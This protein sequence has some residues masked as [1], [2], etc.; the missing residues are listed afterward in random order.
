MKYLKGV[1]VIY[2]FIFPIISFAQ[3]QITEIMYDLDGTDGG[4]EW[5]EIQ[6]IGTIDINP[7]EYKLLENQVNHKVSF[8]DEYTGDNIIKPNSYAVIA[9]NPDKFI[10]DYPNYAGLLLDSAFSLNNT[11]ENLSILDSENNILYSV[12][13]SPEWGAKGTGN[14]LQL[15]GADWIVGEPTPGED[16]A[17]KSIDE[18]E[19][20]ATEDTNSS[21]DDSKSNNKDSTSTH[22]GTN[23]LTNHENKVNFKI[24][25]GRHRYGFINTPINFNPSHNLDKSE[26]IKYKWS[27]GDAEYSTGDHPEHSYY[28]AGDYNV[29]LSATNNEEEVTSRTKVTIR[30][31]N[32]KASL[33]TSGKH[34]DILLINESDFEVNLGGFLLILVLNSDVETS[35]R[36]PRDTI[37]DKKS[38]IKIAAEITDF[39][40]KK[41]TNLENLEILFRYPNG[42]LINSYIF[43]PKNENSIDEDTIKKLRNMV[44]ENKKNEFDLIIKTLTN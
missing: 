1:I 27:F 28:F 43:E 8:L 40:L 42:R 33:T 29:V 24:G 38:Q 39:I 6:N 13:Y 36:I 22:S 7:T 34:V 11:G 18:S 12:N 37:L 32:I 20:D 21:N 9:D 2:I 15:N 5:V 30:E 35:F 17:T 14:T 10:T 26:N 4:R 16:N 44:D 19:S 41:D 23:D 31:P 3:I 25:A